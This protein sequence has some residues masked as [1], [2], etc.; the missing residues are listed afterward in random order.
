MSFI[1]IVN[2]AFNKPTYQEYRYMGVSENMTQ[3]SNAVDG[4]KSNLSVWGEQCVISD[5]HKRTATWW[6]NLTKIH[7]IHQIIIYYRT[8]N[9][10]WGR[11]IAYHDRV[12]FC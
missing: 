2:L 5:V 12:I 6:V 1:L 3:S 4:L 10:D 11:C 7:S 9:G 8:E